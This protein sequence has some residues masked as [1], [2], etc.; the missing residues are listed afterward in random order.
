[1][2]ICVY[3]YNFLIVLKKMKKKHFQKRSMKEAFNSQNNLE[4]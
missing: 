2:Y 4:Y 3:I 1:M